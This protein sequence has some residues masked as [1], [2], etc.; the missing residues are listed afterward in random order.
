MDFFRRPGPRWLLAGLALLVLLTWYA[1]W[2]SLSLERR[3]AAVTSS[4]AAQAAIRQHEYDSLTF[5]IEQPSSMDSA[6]QRPLRVLQEQRGVALSAML[7]LNTQ[8]AD[9]DRARIE[10]FAVPAMAAVAAPADSVQVPVY[11]GTTRRIHGGT[12]WDGYFENVESSPVALTYGRALVSVP[13]GLRPGTSDGRGWCRK[14]GPLQCAKTPANSIMIVDLATLPEP[15]WHQA[16][17]AAIGPAGGR[18]DLLLYVHGFNNSFTDAVT[19]AAQMAHDVGFEG[20]VAAFDWAS[21]HGG[22][23]TYKADE[24]IAKASATQLQEFLGE[25]A[26]QATLGRVIIVAHSMG[27]RVTSYAIRDLSA[28]W[29]RL[30]LGQVVFAA[31]D[32]DSATFVTQL[33][34]SVRGRAE[35]LTLYGSARDRAILASKK[36]VHG[37]RSRVGSG[38]PSIV[39]LDGVDYVDASGVDTDLIGH[40]Y[41][42]ENEKLLNDLFYLLQR[43]LPASKRF[44]DPV[45]YPPGEYYRFR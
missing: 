35:R 11:F 15:Q 3:P 17:N 16:L 38:P 21:L 7:S 28:H 19:R 22:V 41:V 10:A 23:T 14:L 12:S 37:S 32:I 33:A 43:R 18:N 44:L 20:T 39:M 29:P 2:K 24:T 25:L 36:V 30:V 8:L 27:T 9:R 45:P 26:T 42:A 4:I 34:A 5:A 13:A 1:S 31:S 40:A 6:L